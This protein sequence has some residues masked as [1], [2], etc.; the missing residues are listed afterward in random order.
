M[1]RAVYP[2]GPPYR[3]PGAHLL[4]FRRNALAFLC[5]VSQ[6]YGDV[7]AFR[8]GPERVVLL[9]HPEAIHGVLVTQHR[10]FIKARRGEVSK[11]FLGEGLLNSEGEVHHRQRRLIQPAFSRQRLAQYAPIMTAYGLRLCQHWQPGE[12]VDM[13]KSMAQVTLAIAGKT[14]FGTEISAEADDIG[15]AITTLLQF[16]TRFNLPFAETLMRLPLPSNRRLRQAQQVLDSTLYRLIQA[17]RAN[18][19]AETSDVLSVLL[20]AQE[21]EGQ[22][23]SMTD[24]QVHDEALTLLLAGHETTAV[25]LTWTWYLLA[26]HPAVEAKLHAELTSILNGRVPTE[27]DLP[28]LSYTRMVLTEAMRLYPPA[29]MMTRRTLTEYEVGGYTLP[30]RTFMMISPYV[31]HRDARFF[32]SSEVFDPERWAAPHDTDHLKY[33]YFPFGGGPRQCIGEHFA[34]ME[35]LLLMATLAQQWQMRL[36]PGHPVVPSPLVTL[37]PKYGMPMMLARRGTVS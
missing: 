28:H 15:A 23:Q 9:T 37:R 18:G 8:L 5:H 16:S 19:Q 13:A 32:P 10:N 11:Q 22:G 17:R 31:T 1:V 27:A 4:A 26:Q 36:V 12:T 25:A 20:T 2:P 35:G 21:T 30:A 3:F 7:A 33:A 34:W 29:W 14:L 6:T 24:K